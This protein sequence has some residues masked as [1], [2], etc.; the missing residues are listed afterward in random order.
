[1]KTKNPK[2]VEFRIWGSD[3]C[4]ADVSSEASLPAFLS[5]A[6]WQWFGLDKPDSDIRV[7]WQRLC[8]STAD[9]LPAGNKDSNSFVSLRVNSL[10][11]VFKEQALLNCSGKLPGPTA[12]IS[13]CAGLTVRVS[14][15]KRRISGGV[16]MR[17][18]VRRGVALLSDVTRNC[19][20]GI[21]NILLPQTC[22]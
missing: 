4:E 6:A 9:T 19:L 11:S 16:Y 17:R 12:G 8:D 21:S 3:F 5:V 13:R 22:L 20:H 2:S 15:Y 14:L 18:R 1:M 10:L 7:A